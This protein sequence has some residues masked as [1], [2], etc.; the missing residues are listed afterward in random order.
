[1]GI[2]EGISPKDL[3]VFV[4]ALGGAWSFVKFSLTTIKGDVVDIKEENSK[5]D[6]K[7]EALEDKVNKIDKCLGIIEEKTANT[8]S[9]V[10]ELF[11]YVKSK[12]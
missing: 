8:N 3:I 7:I 11:S 5:R 12:L 1:M 4:F 2:L 10:K 6:N 9:N